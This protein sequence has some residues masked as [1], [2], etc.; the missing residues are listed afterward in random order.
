MGLSPMGA[1]P[2]GQVGVDSARR[3]M[4]IQ[5]GDT[6]SPCVSPSVSPCAGHPMAGY[7]PP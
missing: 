1:S 5:L 6:E 3:A 2:E 4:G 7:P